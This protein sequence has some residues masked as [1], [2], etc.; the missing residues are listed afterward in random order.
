MKLIK[1]THVSG[2]KKET[3]IVSENKTSF[4]EPGVIVNF[5]PVA[6]TY[7]HNGNK[8]DSV[9]F[10]IKKFIKKFDTYSVAMN[11]EKSWGILAQDIVD[12]WDSNT[13]VT[14]LFGSAIHK[15]IE[16]YEINRAI[17]DKIS[18]IR[19]SN[20]NYCL[21]KHPILRKILLDFISINKVVG[22]VK[23]EVLIT[24]IELGICG[25]ADR[26]VIIDED[27]K[28]CRIGDYKINVDSEIVKSDNKLL[29]PFDE[30]PANKISKYQLQMSVYANMLQKSGWT[31]DGLDVYVLE[32]EWKHYE[33]EVLKVIN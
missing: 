5:E 23:T 6:H 24:D 22:M 13:E 7:T 1:R 27:K 15:S 14:S 8:L 32:D 21:P 9:T 26:V 10:Y 33:L 11:C 30:L 4:N 25:Q 31:V 3:N 29:P 18:E 20:E 19:G 12:I 17:G 16:H 2:N 28:I